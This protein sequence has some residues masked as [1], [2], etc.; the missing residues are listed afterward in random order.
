MDWSRKEEREVLDQMK[1]ILLLPNKSGL[2]ARS[3][4][5]LYLV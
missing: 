2:Q 5:V 4:I 3:L 1:D